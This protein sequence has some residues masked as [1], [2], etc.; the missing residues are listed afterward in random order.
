[1][2]F[3][4][5]IDQILGDLQQ[6]LVEIGGVDNCAAAAVLC[7]LLGANNSPES[8]RAL[9]NHAKLVSALGAVVIGDLFSPQE[10]PW[11]MPMGES[12]FSLRLLTLC[13]LGLLREDECRVLS[14]GCQ[15]LADE[16]MRED[17]RLL[18]HE[19]LIMVCDGELDA[20]AKAKRLERTALDLVG[21]KP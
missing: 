16:L 2:A 20:E 19:A 11:K 1:M 3:D 4:A 13:D 18:M 14:I 7:A 21:G 9:G 12:P 6:R 8:S 5:Q 15:I 10:T 17:R